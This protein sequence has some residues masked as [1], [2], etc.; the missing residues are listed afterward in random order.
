MRA[1][2][3][4]CEF[5]FKSDR[6]LVDGPD[7]WSDKLKEMSIGV[8][9]IDARTARWPGEDALNRNAPFREAHLPR[10]QTLAG[11]AEANMRWAACAMRRNGSE[12]QSRPLWVAAANE[13]K[14][15][16]PSPDAESAEAVVRLHHRVTKKA[17]VKLARSG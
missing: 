16:L 13:E 4:E 3:R 5:D 11:Y 2:F 12:G 15:H 8:A 7:T 10:R 9:K 14:Q 1:N 6:L 17:G